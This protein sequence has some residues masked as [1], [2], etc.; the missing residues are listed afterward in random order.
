MIW[1]EVDGVWTV[2]KMYK[3]ESWEHINFSYEHKTACP[4]C[5]SQ[6]NDESGD[7]LHVYG[8]N[9]E[10]LSN[11]AFCF[12]CGTTIVSVEKALEDEAERSESKGNNGKIVFKLNFKNPD[13][14]P[15][16]S[17]YGLLPYDK[18]LENTIEPSYNAGHDSSQLASGVWFDSYGNLHGYD[19]S[20]VWRVRSSSGNTQLLT[21]L[22]DGLEYTYSLADSNGNPGSNTLRIGL[23]HFNKFSGGYIGGNYPAIFSGSGDSLS[24][25][26]FCGGFVVIF[27]NGNKTNNLWSFPRGTSDGHISDS[28][29]IDEV[30][31]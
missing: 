6:G 7:N 3:G 10:G 27:G 13:T 22:S 18:L 21:P 23:V 15:A 28:G 2:T 17:F 14:Q 16:L 11:G 30:T 9:E 4:V 26:A 5:R 29:S 31:H 12:C 24:G 25:I 19:S 1:E 20:D 8:N